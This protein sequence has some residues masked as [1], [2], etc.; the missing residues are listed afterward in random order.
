[1][2]DNGLEPAAFDKIMRKGLRERVREFIVS[3]SGLKIKEFENYISILQSPFPNAKS[4]GR[5]ITAPK[6]QVKERL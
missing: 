1:M 3:D 2:K 6:F 5:P 4:R